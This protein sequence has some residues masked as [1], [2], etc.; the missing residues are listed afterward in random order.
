MS[1]QERRSLSNI[2][3]TLLITTIYFIIVYNKYQNGDYDTSNLMKFY[4]I[5]VLIFIPISVGARIV[6]MILF[7]IGGEIKK[8]IKKEIRKELSQDEI[9]EDDLDIVDER[10][11][12]VALQSHRISLVTFSIGFIIALITQAYDLSV[13][14]FFLTLLGFGLLSEIYGSIAE[15][16]YYRRGV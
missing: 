6:L 11:K 1:L 10:D 3:M 2:F 5:R 4:S 14:A 7:R 13:H 16:F 15:I 12:A 8:E 9:E